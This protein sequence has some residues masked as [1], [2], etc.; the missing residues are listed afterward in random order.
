[1]LLKYDTEMLLVLVP[2]VVL[3]VQSK[4]YKPLKEAPKNQAVQRLEALINSRD[5]SQCLGHTKQNKYFNYDSSE[6]MHN[7]SW[8]SLGSS[9]NI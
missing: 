4:S 6:K 7:E 3:G 9:G 2:Q 5:S 8:V 1:M